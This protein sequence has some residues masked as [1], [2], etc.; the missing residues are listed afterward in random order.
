MRQME[1]EELVGLGLSRTGP[2]VRSCDLCD[3]EA[4]RSLCDEVKPSIIIHAAAQRDPDV[5]EHEEAATSAL[6][7]EA[8]RTLVNCANE[9]KAWIIYIST[10]YVFDGSDAPYQI[11]DQPNPLNAYG[12]SKLLG[13]EVLRDADQG[14]V[15][16]VPVL[17]GQVESLGES[18]VTVVAKGILSGENKPI[19]HWGRRFPTHTDDI[20]L[21]LLALIH[22][23]RDSGS[24]DGKIHISA[25][26]DLSK[27]D[28]ACLMAEVLGKDSS[29]IIPNPQEPGGAPRPRGCQL[30]TGRLDELVEVSFRTFRSGIAEAFSGLGLIP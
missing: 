5:C 4:V 6:N 30:D 7:I 16:R 13:E 23:G 10:D 24:I 21:A 14:L 26:E 28:Q 15:V 2:G 27:Y 9:L 19:D 17:Y 29:V 3:G 1:G 20:A 25:A 22:K 8:T 12:K 11:D 18:A